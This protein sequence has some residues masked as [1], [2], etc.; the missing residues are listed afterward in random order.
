[1]K[2]N[3]FELPPP[4]PNWPGTTVGLEILTFAVPGF[5]TSEA[6][7]TAVNWLELKILVC[8]LAPFH[9][10]VE[11]TTKFC[12]VTV[13]VNC[14]PPAAVAFGDSD[15]ML[16]GRPHGSLT[17][18]PQPTMLRTAAVT[19]K[20]EQRLRFA[21]FCNS[22]YYPNGESLSPI[23]ASCQFASLVQTACICG[24]SPHEALRLS[25]E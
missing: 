25:W 12:P 21:R 18:L 15:E 17:L 14:F 11:V 20:N 4:G 2:A 19:S 5:A 7:M 13:K 9:C 23:P 24:S 6:G 16:G 1:M 8:R 22:G 10:R 3:E